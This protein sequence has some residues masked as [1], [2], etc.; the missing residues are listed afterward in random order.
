MYKIKTIGDSFMS[1]AGLLVPVPNPVLSAVRCGLEMVKAAKSL[2]AGW[3]VRVGIHA[4][5][6]VAAWWD[7][8]IPLRPLGDT[9]NTAAR[10]ESH[11]SKAGVNVSASAWARIKD[12]CAGRSLGLVPVKGKARWRSSAWKAP[13]PSRPHPRNRRRGGPAPSALA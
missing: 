1:T 4:G 7:G 6:V 2:P 10:V 9:V 8:S 13:F 11:G 5:P 12:L 3:D